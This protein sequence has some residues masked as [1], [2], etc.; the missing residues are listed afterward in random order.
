[1]LT[2]AA[3]FAVT[4]WTNIYAPTR[5]VIFGDPIGG[6]LAPVFGPGVKDKPVAISPWWRG[7]TPLAHTSYWLGAS[8]RGNGGKPTAIDALR[9][10]VDLE[11]G[12]WLDNHLAEL[13]W[14]MSIRQAPR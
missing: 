3:P 6:P 2:Q 9:A 1:M 10:A 11:S 13:P 8:G 14:E 12:R 5:G 4:R 7:Q